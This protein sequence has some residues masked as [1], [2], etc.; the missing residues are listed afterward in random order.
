MRQKKNVTLEENIFFS[1]EIELPKEIPR[2]DPFF[3]KIEPPQELPEE[4]QFSKKRT[5]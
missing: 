3:S 5:I 4:V 2:D 1:E